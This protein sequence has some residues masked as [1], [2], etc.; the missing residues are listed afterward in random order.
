[1]D[2]APQEEAVGKVGVK[3]LKPRLQLF[4]AN[5]HKSSQDHWK[6]FKKDYNVTS[7]T[8]QVLS[9]APGEEFFSSAK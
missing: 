3:K 1:V 4:G 9:E 8:M 6:K 5:V 7:A 2:R